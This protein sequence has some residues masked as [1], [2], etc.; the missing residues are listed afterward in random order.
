LQFGLDEIAAK[1]IELMEYAKNEEWSK[2]NEI[3]NSLL[4]LFKN[5]KDFLIEKGL[6]EI[7]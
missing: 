6:Y 3:A 5:A 7:E 2:A 4:G 1:G